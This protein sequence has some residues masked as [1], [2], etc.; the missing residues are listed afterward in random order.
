MASP[1]VSRQTLRIIDANLNRIGE[2]L[3]L[4]EDLARLLLNDAT[5]TQQLKTIRHELV[6]SDWSFNQR[7]L[8]FRDSES[9]VGINIEAPEQDKQRELPIMVVA[10]ARRVQEAMR[11]V[12]ELAKIPGAT[13]KLD[14]EK[15]KQARFNLYTIERSLLSR[16]LRQDKVKGVSGLYV[17]VDTEALKGRRHIE[18]A[19][20]AIH[21]GAK[22]VQLR[23]KLQS[24]KELLPIA[25]QLRNL[26][27]EHNVLFI[28]NDYLDLALASDADGLHL[29]QND[30]PIK[31]A[32]KLLP[33]GKILGC[34]TTT[35]D[36][37][38]TAESEGAD[39]IA[40]GSI[41]P[42]SS[43]ETA[44]LIGLEGL[45]QIRQAISL[46]LVAIGGITKDN[47]AEVLAAGAD[48]V[49]VISAVLGAESPEE[50][51]Q[52]IAARFEAQK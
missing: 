43:K 47:T 9:D 49:A 6:T 30:L 17:I 40:A 36:Q 2:G 34:S 15:F 12:E 22:T 37:A 42:T 41:Y 1:Q 24:K 44:K 18:V 7:L 5:L 33:I 52:Q 25:Q 8:Q 26:C 28:I 51:A 45:S 32:R 13:P 19:S 29:G 35:V 50:A 20:E 3:R 16:L 31:V 27:T 38:I 10:N 21:G 46:P 39:Y 48:S 11:V 4:L 14:S 23:D